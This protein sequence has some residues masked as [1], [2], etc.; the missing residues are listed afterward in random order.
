MNL[1]LA[2]LNPFNL[3]LIKALKA[4]VR[5]LNRTI[6][7]TDRSLGISLLTQATDMFLKQEVDRSI[8]LFTLLVHYDN[9]QGRLLD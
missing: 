7:S 2:A 8:Y 6:D 9:L 4:K 5:D 1:K 3:V